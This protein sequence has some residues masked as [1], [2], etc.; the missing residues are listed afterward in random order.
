MLLDC[1]QA[2]CA[3][4][5]ASAIQPSTSMDCSPVAEVSKPGLTWS[6]A[7]IYPA[8][9]DDGAPKWGIRSHSLR[10]VV[11]LEG[12][13]KSQ[14]LSVPVRPV[15]PFSDPSRNL[16]ISSCSGAVPVSTSKHGPDYPCVLVGDCNRGPVM[17]PTLPKFIYPIASRIGFAL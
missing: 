17:P 8:S 14:G 5:T 3:E 15:S 4:S 10:Q 12:H 11:G 16:F 9:L 1:R 6:I 2:S 13:Y 7:N